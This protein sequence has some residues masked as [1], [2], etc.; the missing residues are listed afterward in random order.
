MEHV[1]YEKMPHSSSDWRFAPSYNPNKVKWCVTE[2]CHGANFCFHC[3]GESIYYA[4]RTS[5][6]SKTDQFFGYEAIK[7]KYKEKIL[8]AYNMINSDN[9]YHR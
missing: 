5:I 6:L 2:K 3:N 4:K 7:E 1:S 8:N 9:S